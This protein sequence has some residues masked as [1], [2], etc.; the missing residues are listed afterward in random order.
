MT[1]CYKLAANTYLFSLVENIN[2]VQ[3][4]FGF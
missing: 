4:C 1:C 2:E 3:N